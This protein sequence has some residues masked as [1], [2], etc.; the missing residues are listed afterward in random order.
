[1]K[2]KDTKYGDLTGEIFIGNIDVFGMGLTS[3]EGS[4]K[5]VING[6]FNCGY[7]KLT[8]LKYSPEIIRGGFNCT[9]NQLTTLEFSPKEVDG[10]YECYDNQLV[11]LKGIQ[12]ELKSSLACGKNKLKSLEYA[13]R[14]IGVHLNA[15]DNLIETMY[16]I[17]IEIVGG[18]ACSHNPNPHLVEE[19]YL[20]QRNSNLSLDNFNIKMYE[21]TD[22]ADRY[23]DKNAQDIFLF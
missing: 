22:D 8:S 18:F 11:S 5:I 21:L 14:K 2:F 23:I 19:Y 4:P 17:S 20:K 9:M 16:D 6:N 1:M 15:S 7:N 3:L 12:T 13:P 10:N